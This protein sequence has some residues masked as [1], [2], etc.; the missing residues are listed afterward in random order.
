LRFFSLALLITEIVFA[1]TVWLDDLNLE[2]ATQGW[3]DPHKNQPVEGH[4]L[5][6]AGKIFEHGFGTHAENILHVKLDGGAQ[7]FSASVG[8]DDEADKNPAA[9]VEFFVLS[10]DEV[11]A[12]GKEA[13]CVLTNGDVRVYEKDLEDGGR[14]LGFFNLGSTSTNLQFNQLA[15]IGFT[16]KHHVHDL[17]RQTDLPDMDA[18]DGVLPLTIPAHGVL[19][20]KLTVANQ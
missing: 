18:A 4:P 17:W 16:G 1:E 6:I 2:V 20:Y 5:S 12:L 19:L 15:Q 7:S 10:N 9:S 11:L 3:G 13:I 8:V 14:A